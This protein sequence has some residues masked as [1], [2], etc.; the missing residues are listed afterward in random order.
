MGDRYIAVRVSVNMDVFMKGESPESLWNT[1]ES[2]IENTSDEILDIFPTAM[3]NNYK[4]VSAVVK[5]ID[6][7]EF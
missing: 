2:V 3:M 6:N 7:G 1:G 4:V 5:A